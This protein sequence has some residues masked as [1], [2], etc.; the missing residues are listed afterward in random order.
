MSKLTAKEEALYQALNDWI[1]DEWD[2]YECDL[3]G[4]SC[5]KRAICDIKE[6]LYRIISK[7]RNKKEERRED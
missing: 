1:N 5:E 4:D 3:E 6:L 2:A 7:I